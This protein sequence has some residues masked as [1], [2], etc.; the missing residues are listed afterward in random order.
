MI[1][2]SLA[3]LKGESER[4][5]NTSRST[6]ADAGHA[7]SHVLGTSRFPKVRLDQASL[8]Q[9]QIARIKDVEHLESCLQAH[10]LSEGRN[11][12]ERDV[13]VAITGHRECVPAQSSV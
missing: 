13:H 10:P 1:G 11:L 12:D 8:R 6:A 2:V 7:S 3:G 4:E 5:L 9:C